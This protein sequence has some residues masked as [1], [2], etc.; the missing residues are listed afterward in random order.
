[1]VFARLCNKT[2][3]LPPHTTS[4]A[5]AWLSRQKRIW[6]IAWKKRFDRSTEKG[7]AKKGH[8]NRVCFCFL[9]HAVFGRKISIANS[10]NYLIRCHLHCEGANQWSTPG[11]W[12]LQTKNKNFSQTN[13]FNTRPLICRKLT[14]TH[15]CKQPFTAE[16]FPVWTHLSL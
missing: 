6:I 7:C 9:Q 14:D 15:F 2:R 5:G 8:L 12:D 11:F 4:S 13:E 16:V 3:W 10:I 1:M